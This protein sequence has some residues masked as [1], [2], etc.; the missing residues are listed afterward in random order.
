[1]T[2]SETLSTLPAPCDLIVAGVKRP[3]A[4]VRPARLLGVREAAAYLG[5]Q[6]GTLRNWLSAKRL[7]YVKIGRL[8]KISMEDLDHFIEQNTVKGYETH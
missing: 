6:P 3:R 2:K 8:T 5:L 7:P 4:A 1:M